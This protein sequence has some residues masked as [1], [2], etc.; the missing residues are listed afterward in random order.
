MGGKR[1]S[2]KGGKKGRVKDGGIWVGKGEIY[3]G[4]R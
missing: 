1:E 2:I 3:D 4:K